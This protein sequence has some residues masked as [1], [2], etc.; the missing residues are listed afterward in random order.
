MKK[1]LNLT[2]VVMLLLPLTGCRR[3]IYRPPVYRPV[4][5][6]PDSMVHDDVPKAEDETQE[7]L[8]EIEDEPVIVVPDIPQ[9]SDLM[10][11]ENRNVSIEKVMREGI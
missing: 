10:R 6:V 9:E 8:D 1:I 11:E 5:F 2:V 3:Y 4:E 7:M